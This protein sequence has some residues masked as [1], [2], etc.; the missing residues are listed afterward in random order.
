[1]KIRV[2]GR[3]YEIKNVSAIAGCDLESDLRQNALL[4]EYTNNYGEKIESVVFGYSMP[5]CEDDFRDMCDD[6][7]AWESDWEVIKTVKE[8]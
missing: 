2:D 7:C 4:V 3:T 5:E 6:S 1:M 8:I